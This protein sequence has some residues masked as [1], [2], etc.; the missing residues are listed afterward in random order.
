[1]RESGL[2]HVELQ[3]LGRMVLGKCSL[4]IRKKTLTFS[5]VEASEYSEGSF[6]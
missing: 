2:S 5:L 3:R 4:V 1:M 6:C